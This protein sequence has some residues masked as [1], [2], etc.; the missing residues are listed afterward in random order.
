[1]KAQP[2]PLDLDATM[3]ALFARYPALC[4]F[5]VYEMTTGPRARVV[6]EALAV[7]PW[8]GREPSEEL[9]HD[10]A[11]A[12]LELAEESPEAAALLRGRTFA[13]SIH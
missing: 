11:G 9:V 8:A 13:P 6:F 12:L 3:R 5:S 1:M 4:G 7:Q 2:Q 10:L